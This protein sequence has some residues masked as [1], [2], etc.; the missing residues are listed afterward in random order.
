MRKF[1]ASEIIEK[2]G[3]SRLTKALGDDWEG[4]LLEAL[5]FVPVGLMTSVVSEVSKLD[6]DVVSDALL[7]NYTVALLSLIEDR[8]SK[9]EKEWFEFF[10][11]GSSDSDKKES[12]RVK[13]QTNNNFLFYYLFQDNTRLSTVAIIDYMANVIY[14]DIESKLIDKSEASQMALLLS[15]AYGRLKQVLKETISREAS[16]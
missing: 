7:R 11:E 14:L 16:K 13:A 5:D 3:R 12:F 1:K 4:T 15:V 9:D 8:F 10:K 6:G 2:S